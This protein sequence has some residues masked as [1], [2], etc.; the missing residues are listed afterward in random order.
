VGEHELDRVLDRD[1]LGLPDPV[2][3]LDHGGEGGGLAHAGGAGDQHVAAAQLGHL[4]QHRGR[5]VEL[6]EAADLQR[7]HAQHDVEETSLARD[8]DAEAA[9]VRQLEGQVDLVEVHRGG[10]GVVP[11]QQPGD[12]LRVLLR[13]DLVAE[14][15]EIAVEPIERQVPH[16]E[17]DVRRALLDAEAKQAVKLLAIHRS[18]SFGRDGVHSVSC[19]SAGGARP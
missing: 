11:E 18:P 2:H 5:Q 14:L 7:D 10:L 1:D 6:L 15:D 12:R 8:V 16:L 17:V 4:A 3:L 19:V 13:E 9:L